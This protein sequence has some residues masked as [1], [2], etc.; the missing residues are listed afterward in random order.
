MEKINNLKDLF[1]NQVRDIYTAEKKVLSPF[2]AEIRNHASSADLKETID[3]SKRECDNH[4]QRLNL[5]FEKLN[6]PPITTASEKSIGIENI[7][8]EINNV[9]NRCES[10]NVRDAAI[11]SYLQRIN[12]YEIA[13]YGSLRTFAEELGHNDLATSIQKSLDEE[14]KIDLK[15][16]KLATERI[17]EKAIV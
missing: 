9:V 1:T 15:L 8:K 14:K 10:K 5:V 3:Q 16:T 17:N 13:I 4:V 2:Y 11:V 6:L 12:H 7:I